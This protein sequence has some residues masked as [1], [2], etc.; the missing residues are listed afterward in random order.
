MFQARDYSILLPLTPREMDRLVKRYRLDENGCWIWTGRL[1]PK[2]YG[3]A[4]VRGSY[5]LAH[6]LFHELFI[7]HVPTNLVVH[8]K[9]GN[10]ACC[11][12]A[13][14]ELTTCGDNSRLGKRLSGADHPLGRRTHCRHGHPLSGDNCR[15][16]VRAGHV[17]RICRKCVAIESAARYRRKRAARDLGISQ[18]APLTPVVSAIDP[19]AFWSYEI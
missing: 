12:P 7:R 2:G 3:F 5:W 15:C 16:Y 17:I 6:R 18:S 14:Q 9:C 13:H 4:R 1:T 10:R 19:L 8:H 11:N